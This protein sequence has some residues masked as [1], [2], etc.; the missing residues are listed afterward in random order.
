MDQENQRA[1]R[2]EFF[3]TFVLVAFGLASVAQATLGGAAFASP[4][5]INLAWGLAVMLGVAL[6]ASISGAHLNPAV[7]IAL[8]VHRRFPWSKVPYYIL[9]Q[10][11]GAFFA[12]E[13]VYLTY[14]EALQAYDLGVRAVT[15][16]RATA[17]IFATYPAS[18]LST[19]PG[20]F[21]D[22]VVGTA[23]LFIGILA[24]TDPRNSDWAKKSVPLLVGAL[25]ALIG[26]TF[27]LNAG[28]AINPAR[29]FGPRLF[30]FLSGWGVEVFSAGNTWWWVPVVAPICGAVLGG[31][32]YDYF[33]PGSAPSPRRLLPRQLALEDVRS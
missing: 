17:G 10:V 11:A 8:A 24:F 32:L 33:L 20:G 19:F 28:Y 30:T 27:A 26:M 21:W 18:Y 25:V 5:A 12:A 7:T 2:A 9:A 1:F 23:L 6:T 14:F 3:G 29:D 22:Q 16:A 4:L 15:G 13:A 31:S